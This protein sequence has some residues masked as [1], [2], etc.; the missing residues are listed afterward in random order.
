MTPGTDPGPAEPPAHTQLELTPPLPPAAGSCSGSASSCSSSSRYNSSGVK[1]QTPEQPGGPVY[2]QQ[3]LMV[4]KSHDGNV[5]AQGFQILVVLDEL[6]E[7]LLHLLGGHGKP[8]QLEI[9]HRNDLI[10]NQRCADGRAETILLVNKHR[11]V[12]VSCSA[13]RFKKILRLGN[14]LN[15]PF[16]PETFRNLQEPLLYLQK[17]FWVPSKTFGIPSK[18]SDTFRN[19]QEPLESF[20]NLQKP[21]G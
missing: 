9:V 6:V 21:S 13:K 20:R 10:V 8:L 16:S 12:L 7:F 18:L 2:D 19:L 11:E 14:F 3:Q 1:L 17:T 5:S 15:L 4:D